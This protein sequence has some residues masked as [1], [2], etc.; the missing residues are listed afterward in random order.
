MASTSED[1]CLCILP[2]H[3]LARAQ[4]LEC[5]VESRLRSLRAPDRQTVHAICDTIDTSGDELDRTEFGHVL[6]VLLKQLFTRYVTQVVLTVLS[7]LM[8]HHVCVALKAALSRLSGSH[9]AHLIPSAAIK[10]GV[11]PHLDEMLV[12]MLLLLSRGPIF[13]LVDARAEAEARQL[14]SRNLLT[15]GA[16]RDEADS[17]TSGSTRSPDRCPAP[18]KDTEESQLLAPPGSRC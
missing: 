12:C 7:F 15:A 9:V 16:D 11:P 5:R 10:L 18:A 3:L 17:A 14:S 4:R 2:L 1:A 13:S 8:A 6:R